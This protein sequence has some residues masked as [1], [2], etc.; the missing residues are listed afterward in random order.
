MLEQISVI[1][2]QHYKKRKERLGLLFMLR[3]TALRTQAMLSRE[4]IMSPR[5]AGLLDNFPQKK[6]KKGKK[7]IFEIK[8]FMGILIRT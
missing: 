3:L 5:P 1:N 8:L 7:V 6:K 2:T 4:R